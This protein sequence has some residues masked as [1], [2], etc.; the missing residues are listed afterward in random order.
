MSQT[1]AQL[2]DNI[3]DNVQL[4]ARNS[5]RFADT[6]SS[7]YVAFKAPATVS[8]NVTWTLPAADG[9]ANYVL[10]TDG[11][12]T[13]SWIADPAGQWT[14]SGSNIYFTGGNVGIGDSSPSNPLSVT[15]ASA[16]NGDVTLTGASYN[17]VWDKS[18]NALEFA[19]SAKASFGAGVDLSIYHTDP[20][21]FIK[22]QNEN[23]HLRILSGV[24]GNGGI[25]LKNR[26]DDETYLTC[27]SDGAVEL[28]YDNSKKLNTDA[29][30]IS[31][32][33]RVY[34]SGVSDY[35]FLVDDD[36]KIGLGTGKDLQIYH[37]GIN[38]YILD[39]GT[40]H[41]NIK[42]NGTDISFTKTPHEHL[43][44]FIVD[45]AC[46]LYHNNGVR[47]A[48]TS[49]GATVT[50]A[51][52]TVT[53]PDSAGDARLFCKAGQN[54]SAYI[55][56]HADE[57]DN[58]S[59]KWRLLA[60]NGG[61]F[62]IQ[63]DDGSFEN[64][65]TA[66]KDGAVELYYDNEKVFYTRGDGAQVQNTNGDGVLY[67][68][69]SEG[70]EALVKL[71][72]DDGDD[73]ADKFQL[74]SHADNYFA[75]QNYA[76][77]SWETN[78]KAT[79]NGNVE[80][81]YDNSKKFETTSNGISV[82]GSVIP[83]GNVNLGDS[84]NSNNN[85][86]IAGA[87]DDLQIYHNGTDSY[88]DDDGTGQLRLC[89]NELVGLNAAHSE[90]TFKAFED[91]AVE[92]YYNGTKHFETT[93]AG[94]TVSGNQIITQ[95]GSTTAFLKLHNGDDTD[96]AK[97]IYSSSSNA[98]SIQVAESGSGFKIFC[99]GTN[100]GNRRF[101]AYSDTTA[102]V[103]PYGDENMGVF[104]PNGAVELYYDN[105]KKFETSSGG[106]INA[107]STFHSNSNSS[108]FFNSS[109]GGYGGAI[110]LGRAGANNYHVTGSTT[111]DF[112]LAA[113]YEKKMIFGATTN[114]SGAPTIKM[115]INPDG[116]IDGNFNDT[117]DA[118]L[119]ENINLMPDD[120]ITDIK[121]L[122]PVIF[123][124]KDTGAANNVS[125]F[126]AQE[127]KEV[128]PNLVNGKEWSEEDQS[129]R[130]SINTIG[131]VAHLTKA[132][133]E[134]IAKIETLETKVAALESA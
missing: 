25:Q 54:G 115:T 78:I 67:V 8:S 117:S 123:D 6:D 99:G 98:A 51:S 62:A 81:Y 89:S 118:K 63:Y 32:T 110:G 65:L 14:T 88:I 3:K 131:V 42:T 101:Q 52:L 41:L 73:N 17:A 21:G 50:G 91:G 124:W 30:G 60:P 97:F 132:L 19:D 34:A 83:T 44:K 61:P 27:I 122:K 45:G 126:I 55:L 33:G 100:A 4:D 92:L 120:A 68:V 64:S 86:F 12:G 57:G 119:K 114:T 69:G 104:T 95:S 1:K 46:E 116:Q 49:T 15:G 71:F 107:G 37:D 102:T 94:A 82:T 9:S 112:V 2:L 58:E 59:D 29:S 35:G 128:L 108:I 74:V 85:R 111:G 125:G 75:V 18:D 5:L 96:G 11:S 28:Y 77:G 130:Y 39:N 47:I 24:S 16:F 109:S 113:S 48:T 22:Y 90:Y 36:V 84:T 20:N 79:G 26:T 121:Q 87:S 129:N 23:G 80:L 133:Q 76:S 40:G 105:S 127:V 10:A 66:T 56:L 7:H 103:L 134:A 31:V 43:A 38:S 72:A 13:L 70:N 93:S 53:N 106:V